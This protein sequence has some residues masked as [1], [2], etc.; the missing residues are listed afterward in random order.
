MKQEACV[1][2]VPSMPHSDDN[3]A[4]VEDSSCDD[5]VAEVD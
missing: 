3:N 1:D 2:M 5:A 4:E